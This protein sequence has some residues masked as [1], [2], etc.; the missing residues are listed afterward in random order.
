[1]SA[2]DS[3]CRP[4]EE[5]EEEEEEEE[6]EDTVMVGGAPGGAE[7]EEEK[8][9]EERDGEGRTGNARARRPAARAR[10]LF[11]MPEISSNE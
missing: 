6:E 5:G 11:I 2:A 7:E 4:G 10:S 8:Q 1:V 3:P 9:D